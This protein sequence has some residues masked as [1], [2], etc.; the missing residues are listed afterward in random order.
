M[1]R[2]RNMSWDGLGAPRWRAPHV[3]RNRE[4]AVMKQFMRALL[5]LCLLLPLGAKAEIFGFGIGATADPFTDIFVFGDSLSDTG[6]LAAFAN[7]QVQSLAILDPDV[8]CK[9]VR[10][11]GSDPIPC[12]IIPDLR[13][14]LC[15]A[16]F[17]ETS[18]LDGDPDLIFE[19]PC[20]DLFFMNSRVS[21]GP[22]A[23][24]VLANKL[25]PPPSMPP[26]AVEPSLHFLPGFLRPFEFGTNYAV[27]G[28]HARVRIDPKTG[29][30]EPEDLGTQI[31]A[32]LQLDHG[33]VAPS[34]ALYVVMIGGNDVIDA[35]QA[36]LDPSEDP[37]AIS[38]A[39]VDAIGDNINLLIGA[40]ARKFLVANSPNIGSIP[41]IK[42]AAEEAGVPPV[43]VRSV[44][45]FVT[46]KF[47]RQLAERL[48]QIQAD[49]PLVEIKQ[50]NLFRSFERV[51]FLGKLF[52]VFENIK[53][54]CFDSGEYR[55]TGAR[56]FD[57]D[58]G[59]DKFD[60]FVFFDDLHPTG[61]VHQFVGK[62]LS[63][64]ARKLID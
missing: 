46:I 37:R 50:F 62:A 14:G 57:P 54:A 60:D 56:N 27:A 8:L 47:N 3:V 11:S 63:K 42:I 15:F 52:G 34:E 6:N 1:K 61:Q 16:K 5:C 59:V 25:P 24:E 41:A 22:V 58:C 51:R 13:V 45:T 19:F 40:G 9:N 64:A 35:I 38:A 10:E 32:F 31:F 4:G 36:L 39:A 23:V 20:D 28:A 53:D 55:D 17:D 48:G 7:L 33:G 49:Q 30:P 26:L 21:N 18:D 44:A 43:L 12:I 29:N 2:K